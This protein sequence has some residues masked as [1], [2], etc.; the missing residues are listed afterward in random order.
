MSRLFKKKHTKLLLILA[1]IISL[2]SVTS[3]S[4]ADWCYSYQA[5]WQYGHYGLGC[6]Y[7]G[8]VYHYD[9]A[10]C[11]TY[12]GSMDTAVW[13][14]GIIPNSNFCGPVDPWTYQRPIGQCL[15]YTCTNNQPP[16]NAGKVGTACT[17]GTGACK[18]DGVFVCSSNGTGPVCNAVAGSP[19]PEVCEGQTTTAT[20]QLMKD[21]QQAAHVLLE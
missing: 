11:T 17:A 2:F 10:T 9:E 8:T 14:Y 12:S 18:K 3:H 13:N 6:Y 21:F 7:V 1:L 20:A 4:E 5:C 16:P 15:T 19:S